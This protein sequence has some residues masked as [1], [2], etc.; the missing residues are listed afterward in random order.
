M[1]CTIFLKES[2]FQEALLSRCN[3]PDPTP[4]SP[5]PMRPWPGCS[6]LTTGDTEWTPCH[7]FTSAGKGVKRD[8]V[9]LTR[10]TVERGE[11]VIGNNSCK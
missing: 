11:I 2:E 3:C 9:I 10:G 8:N 4:A 6:G 7:Q 5:F 1:A